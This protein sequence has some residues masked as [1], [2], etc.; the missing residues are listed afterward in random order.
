MKNKA[1]AFGLTALLSLPGVAGAAAVTYDGGRLSD[2]DGPHFQEPLQSLDE[3]EA[4]ARQRESINRLQDQ[5][6]AKTEEILKAGRETSK[7]AEKEKK[8]TVQWIRNPLF[9]LPFTEIR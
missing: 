5:P 9:R 7:E 6:D 4:E 3:V 1:L 2:K 8:N